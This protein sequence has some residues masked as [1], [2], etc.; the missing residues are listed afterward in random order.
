MM[1]KTVLRQKSFERPIVSV[2]ETYF[3][4]DDDE[5]DDEDF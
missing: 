3:P 5:D 2:L 4:I 1:N